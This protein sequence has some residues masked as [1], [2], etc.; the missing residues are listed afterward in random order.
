MPYQ[1]L[2]DLLNLGGLSEPNAGMV[3]IIGADPVLQTPYRMGTAAA[4]VIAA[5]GVAASDLWALRTGRHQRVSVDMRAATAAFRSYKYLRV[6]GGPQ[7]T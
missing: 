3:E 2:R 5:T 1:S 4:A 6:N 7:T